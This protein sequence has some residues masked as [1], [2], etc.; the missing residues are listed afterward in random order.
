M[1][2]RIRKNGQILC[3]AIHPE[4]PGDTYINDSLHYEMSVIHKVI[5]A[6]YIEKHKTRGEWW[7][8]N[9]IPPGIE[10]DKFYLENNENKIS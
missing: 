6:E 2:L 1:A 4:K 5:G 9:N 7:Y 8:I 3:A 10:I